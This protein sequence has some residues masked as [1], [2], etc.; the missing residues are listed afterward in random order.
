MPIANVS[1]LKG[2]PGEALHGARH[3]MVLITG[4]DEPDAVMI[5]RQSGTLLH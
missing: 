3:D 4:R 2:N 5:R 1:G